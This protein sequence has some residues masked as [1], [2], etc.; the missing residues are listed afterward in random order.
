M[1]KNKILS[2]TT[3][4]LVLLMSSCG[5]INSDPHPNPSL[6]GYHRM[7]F[8]V[9]FGATQRKEIG[10]GN[11]YLLENQSLEGMFFKFYGMGEGTVYFK[12]GS[13]GIDFSARFNKVMTYKL[14]DLIAEPTKC[15]IRIVAESDAIDGKQHNVVESGLLKINV[16]PSGSKALGIKYTRRNP[17]ILKE[18]SSL[19]Q[20]SMQRKEGPLTYNEKFTVF[21]DLEE[22]GMYRINGCGHSV[23]DSFEGSKFSISL[24]ELVG[25]VELRKED[26]CDYE[27]VVIPHEVD[28]SYYGRFSINIYGKSVVKLEPMQYSLK[29]KPF[30]RKKKLKA[31]GNKNYIIGCA[32]NNKLSYSYRCYEK[33]ASSDKVYWLR[34]LTGNGRKS[35]FAIKD[36]KVIWSE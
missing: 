8:D 30:S 11:I 32:I 19:G 35:I 17:F 12:S 13:C 2:V 15:S 34:S 5:H 31:I 4:M 1:F 16:I 24:K 3:L 6:L 14:S 29:K 27:V 9:S 26:S 22:G 21:T 20:A 36:G 10:I 25:K 23:S 18:Y 33:K 7:E 28:F